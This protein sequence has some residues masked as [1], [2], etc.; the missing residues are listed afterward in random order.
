MRLLQCLVV[1]DKSFIFPSRLLSLH[2]FAKVSL[3]RRGLQ[4]CHFVDEVWQR[5][6]LMC[7]PLLSQSYSACPVSPGHAM[8]CVMWHG[9][10]ESPVTC[11]GF[12]M[13]GGAHFCDVACVHWF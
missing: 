4:R 5:W 3:H 7:H 12:T 13:V 1:T 11:T 2:P 8:W 6:P 10:C 9:N